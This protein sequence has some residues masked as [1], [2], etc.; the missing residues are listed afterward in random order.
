MKR[1]HVPPSRVRYETKKPTLSFRLTREELE[2]VRQM[3]MQKSLTLSELMMRGVH[4]EGKVKEGY[5][6]GYRRGVHDTMGRFPIPCTG[7][8]EA[9][10]LDMKSP[11]VRQSVLKAFAGFRHTGCV[12]KEQRAPPPIVVS[13]Q[14]AVGETNP[15]TSEGN[16]AASKIPVPVPQLSGENDENS[17]SPNVSVPAEAPSSS[18]SPHS[19]WDGP[20]WASL[21][22]AGVVKGILDGV[23]E[24]IRERRLAR[25]PEF[26]A[27]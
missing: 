13:A 16:A 21:F 14:V 3:Q 19:S 18:A 17:A 6:Q 10:L 15:R 11:S 5:L 24:A 8:G 12:E 25:D 9:I 1:K 4:L 23:A 27:T 7:C 2:V 22:A 20:W 26:E